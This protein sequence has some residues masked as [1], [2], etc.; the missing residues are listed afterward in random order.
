[1]QLRNNYDRQVFNGDLGRIHSIDPEDKVMHVEFDKKL[2]VYPF[3]ELDELSLAYAC[4]IHKSQGSEFPAVVIPLHG[5]HYV[6]LRRRLLYTAV[7]RGKKLVCIVGS[8]SALQ[9]AVK[10]S[11]AQPRFT[12]LRDRLVT[13]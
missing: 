9:M 11:R 2:V 6:M 7:T 13:A 4:T 5:Q 1:M 8:R 10:N 12:S 3:S